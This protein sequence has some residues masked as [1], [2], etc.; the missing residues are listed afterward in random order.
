M[1]VGSSST[2]GK[3]PLGAPSCGSYG[4]TSV[5]EAAPSRPDCVYRAAR[6]YPGSTSSRPSAP[7]CAPPPFACSPHWQRG[8]IYPCGVE[9]LWQ[10]TCRG[11]WKRA[12]WCTATLR[13]GTRQLARTAK[14]VCAASSSPFMAWRKRGAAG[15]AP[16]SLGSSVGDS[17][18]PPLTPVCSSATKSSVARSSR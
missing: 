17:S 12:R 1:A 14:P 11:S 3:F 10:L 9:I 15:S 2:E 8:G 18:S 5:N 6:R 4:F 13:R 16:S 7:R